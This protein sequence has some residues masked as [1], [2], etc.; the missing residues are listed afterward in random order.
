MDAVDI[1]QLVTSGTALAALGAA[2]WQVRS[3]R[4]QA[5]DDRT[6]A[7]VAALSDLEFV[8]SLASSMDAL[9]LDGTTEE[10]AWQKFHACDHRDQLEIAA[11][12]NQIEMVAGLYNRN[13]VNRRIV[14]HQLDNTTRVVFA[15]IGWWVRRSRATNPDYFRE[16]ELMLGWFAE[17][18]AR[19]AWHTSRP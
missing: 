14:Q 9:R 19:T 11:P 18:D 15:R 10:A 6:H 3:S 2:V 7:Y 8:Q 1:A 17:Q 12:F 4:L 5:R 13:H 16:W